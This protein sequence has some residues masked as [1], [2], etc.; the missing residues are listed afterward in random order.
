MKPI[1]NADKMPK[2]WFWLRPGLFAMNRLTFLG[3]IIAIS[4]LFFFPIGLMLKDM[5]ME[6]EGQKNFARQ[7]LTGVEYI[8]GVQQVI[9][10]L[11]KHR[12]T[13]NIVLN[14]DASAS[15][16][17]RQLQEQVA[18][19]MDEVDKLDGRYGASLKTSEAWSTVRAQWQELAGGL[20]GL[21]AEDSFSRHS[22]LIDRLLVLIEQAGDASALRL[23]PEMG[24]YYL[25]DISTG[26][27]PKIMERIGLAR[28]FGSGLA[29]KQQAEDSDRSRMVAWSIEIEDGLKEVRRGIDKVIQVYPEQRER[30]LPAHENSVRAIESFNGTIR[31][32]F[33]RDGQLRIGSADFFAQGTQALDTASRY[34]E[35]S[36]T[37]LQAALE[38][39]IVDVQRQEVRW[40]ALLFV[41]FA[42]AG[43]LY[44]SFYMA[45]R[46][47]IARLKATTVKLA[48]GD[49]RVRVALQT[50]DEMRDIGEAVDQMAVQFAGMMGN[51]R[52][53]SEHVAASSEELTAVSSQAVDATHRIAGSMQEI[54]TGAQ[55]QTTTSEESMSALTELAGGINRIA[56]NSATVSESATDA[57]RQAHNGQSAV[58]QAIAQI[59]AINRSAEETS[60]LVRRLAERSAEIGQIVEV[61]RGIS[62]QT[63]LLALNAQIEA[64]RAG[65]H[66]SGFAVVAGEVKK[67]AEQ[68]KQSAEHITLLIEE[69]VLSVNQAEAAM[70]AG[71]REVDRGVAA[72]GNTGDV[73]RGIYASV[74]RVAGQIEEISAASQEMSAG[75][76]QLAASFEEMVRIARHA[77]EQSREVSSGTENQ[78]ASME[79]IASSAESLSSSA[80]RLLG[81]ISRFRT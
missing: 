40:F 34:F 63:H 61:L 4:L 53:L 59:G 37:A 66:G 5:F 72:I 50:R 69:V 33:L 25:M 20:S 79:E 47:A 67:L 77:S 28:G 76:E 11:Q 35:E 51:L 12:G 46:G 56:E 68:S 75:T 9:L 62:D 60:G 43:Y 22:A 23:D 41:F 14:G 49:L 36:S 42:A 80:Q 54:S 74:D 30:L 6:Y 8:R 19:A 24:T 18:A 31:D 65:E 57:A 64:A 70:E 48:E 55:Q 71:K 39:R 17:L 13:A 58:Q 78:L 38:Q 45:L 7:E 81:D 27:L 16:Q 1:A 44:L 26:Q 52:S 3:K 15:D 32:N 73:F 2:G 21:K 29:A 10:G